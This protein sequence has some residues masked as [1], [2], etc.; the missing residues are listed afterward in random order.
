MSKL[1]QETDKGMNSHTYRKGWT[2]GTI[3]PDKEGEPSGIGER[4]LRILLRSAPYPTEQAW[5]VMLAVLLP[6]VFAALCAAAYL[7]SSAH[8]G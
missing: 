1:Q 3:R 7:L 8:A 5:K 6:L 4:I 2:K